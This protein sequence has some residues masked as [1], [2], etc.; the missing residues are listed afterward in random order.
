MIFDTDVEL[1]E[2]TPSLVCQMQ[3]GLMEFAIVYPQL[4]RNANR[5]V[6]PRHNTHS[7]ISFQHKYFPRVSHSSYFFIKSECITTI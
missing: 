3:H 1:Q 2:G 6:D 5:T 4:K 7:L